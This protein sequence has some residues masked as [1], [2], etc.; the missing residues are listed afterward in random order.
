MAAS[1]NSISFVAILPLSYEISVLPV[2]ISFCSA[3]R[4]AWIWSCIYQQPR[5]VL[6]DEILLRVTYHLLV[7]LKL[8]KFAVEL[9]NFRFG[10]L[11]R[12]V[13]HR[14]SVLDSFD[15]ELV[16]SILLHETLFLLHVFGKELLSVGQSILELCDLDRCNIPEH[17][18][19]S[20]R[21][22]ICIAQVDSNRLS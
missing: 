4:R 13:C 11:A 14:A 1:L 6:L 22:R 18:V 10:V 7:V 15:L 20:N 12:L 3:P 5:K 16:L 17:L 8:F 21:H 19:V 2:S 9:G